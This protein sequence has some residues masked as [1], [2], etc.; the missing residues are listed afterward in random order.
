MVKVSDEQFEAMV[1]AGIDAI[2]E[3]FAAKLDNIAVTWQN[4]PDLWQRTKMRLK[5]WQSLFGL[6]EGIP[7]T[8]RGSNY[9][10]V[11]P[12]KIT[13]FRQPLASVA[14]DEVELAKLVKN[15]VWHEFAHHFG[16]S[17]EEIDRRSL[18]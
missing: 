2:P 8:K 4:S 1:A 6:Y 3:E 7:K 15:T 18:T 14:D 5:P 10:L 12:D 17:D 11:L 13:I 16:L 9:S